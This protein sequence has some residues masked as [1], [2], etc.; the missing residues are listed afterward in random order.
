MPRVR[1]AAEV[2]WEG[3]VARGHGAISAQ[4][5]AFHELPFSLATRVGQAEGKTSPEEL[6]A[7]AHAGCYAMSLAGELTKRGNPP[8]HLSVTAACTLDEVQGEGHQIVSME[9]TA[10]GSVP[11]ID[12]ETFQLAA[13]A[14]DAG[15][16]IS[17]LVRASATVTVNAELEEER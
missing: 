2:T 4:T 5:G 14:A 11:S 17:H 10:R 1:R 7:A 15:C 16:T 12:S 8:E 13:A 9:L 3:N 6:L